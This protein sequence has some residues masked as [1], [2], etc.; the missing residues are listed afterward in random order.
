[1]VSEAETDA[2]YQSRRSGALPLAANDVVTVLAGRKPGERAWVISLRDT[3]PSP[4][5]LIEYEDRS[6]ETVSLANLRAQ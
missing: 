1:M 6:D 3:L 2:F 5:Y 4:A